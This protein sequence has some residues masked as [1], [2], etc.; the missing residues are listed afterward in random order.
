MYS[1]LR[2]EQSLTVVKKHMIS[3]IYTHGR[4]DSASATVEAGRIQTHT[5]QKRVLC[6][7]A[8]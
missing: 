6:A 1:T 7:H 4:E 8:R 2:S 5:R 3:T